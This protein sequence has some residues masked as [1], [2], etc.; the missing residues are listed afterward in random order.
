MEENFS[1]GA[2]N[3]I[4]LS[5]SEAQ[6]LGSSYIGTEHI[7]LGLLR[8]TNDTLL[9]LLEENGIDIGQMC[10]A[11][12]GGISIPSPSTFRP[13]LEKKEE[14]LSLN[15]QAER[16]IKLSQLEALRFKEKI[17]PVHIL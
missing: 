9:L 6:R 16:A 10:R 2:L 17:A 14:E 5:H 1:N 15:L 8:S 4:H 12:E 13:S 3:A 11:L 7:T